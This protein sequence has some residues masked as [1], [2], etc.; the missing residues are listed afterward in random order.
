MKK[1]KIFKILL[2]IFWMGVIFSFSN[3]KATDS[4]KLSNGFIRNTIVKVFNIKDEN[5]IKKLVKPVRKTAHFT[6]YLIL[7]LLVLNSFDMVYK[8]NIIYSVL[9]CLFYSVFDEF[10]QMFI[11][12]R[13][14]E[15]FDVMIDTTGSFFGTMIYKLMTLRK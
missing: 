8:K 7:G 1:K 9:I 5:T 6:I 12:G 10:H 2:V 4:S 15:I 13:S 14:G 3:Q 11:D